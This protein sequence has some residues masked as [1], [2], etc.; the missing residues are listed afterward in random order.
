MN[1]IYL[2]HASRTLLDEETNLTTPFNTEHKKLLEYI[3]DL[4]RKRKALSDED[5]KYIEENYAI[6]KIYNTMQYN[7][8]THA[9][10]SQKQ[11]RKDTVEA[12]L[13]QFPAKKV[14]YELVLP[15]LLDNNFDEK[16]KAKAKIEELYE[17]LKGIN[18]SSSK[19]GDAIDKWDN[20]V[21]SNNFNKFSNNLNT[22]IKSLSFLVSGANIARILSGKDKLTVNSTIGLANDISLLTKSIANT[23]EKNIELVKAKEAKGLMQ[24]IFSKEN[25]NITKNASGKVIAFL[26]IPA[27]II[28]SGFE[29][30]R[31]A[32]DE[33][34]DAAFFMTLKSTLTLTLLLAVPTTAAVFL[35]L[36]VIELVW[37]LL[38]H[39]VIDSKLEKYIKKSLFFKDIPRIDISYKDKSIW[40]KSFKSE[41]CF[42]AANDGAGFKIVAGL[43]GDH[44][45]GGGEQ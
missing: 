29:I 2:L 43:F 36:A 24:K 23:M 4:T 44:K 34:Y 38:S 15:N 12:F 3:S 31:Y 6:H 28:S 41:S 20:R 42:D 40:G 14:K 5:K 35:L 25:V 13:N 26:G 21:S 45:V 37:Y 32:K 16:F 39:M 8:I 22:H 1:I 18:G 30:E 9:F 11:K 19:V 27:I 17:T 10:L 7:L 33:D